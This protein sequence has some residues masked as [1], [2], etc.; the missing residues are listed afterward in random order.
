MRI[1]AKEIAAELGVS[2]STVSLALNGRPGVNP[3]TRERILA[4][5]RQKEQELW[6]KAAPA[7]KGTILI[8]NYIKNGTIME[9][10]ERLQTDYLSCQETCQNPLIQKMTAF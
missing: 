2:A 6:A 9:H 1:K 3:E 7:L 4:Y 10:M 8:L 5:V